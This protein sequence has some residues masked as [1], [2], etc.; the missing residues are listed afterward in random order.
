MKREIL[1]RGIEL[2]STEWIEGY[3]VLSSNLKRSFIFRYADEREFLR[4]EV[5]PETVGQFICRE[6]RHGNKIF[7]G[8]VIKSFGVAWEV[9]W[10][11][12][13]FA[14]KNILKTHITGISNIRDPLEI[15]SNIHEQKDRG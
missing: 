12:C 1:F 13:G 4:Y 3:L 9:V 10:H 15:I 6:D 8:H 11:R 14:M 7:V 2:G 5:D